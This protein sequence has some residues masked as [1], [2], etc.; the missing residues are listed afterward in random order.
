MRIPGIEDIKDA[1]ITLS[2]I[3]NITPLL[4]SYK[5]SER[6]SAN[7]HIKLENFQKTGSFKIR[8]I[9]NKIKKIPEGRL[10]KG[11]I[12]F[13]DPNFGYALSYVGKLFNIP[14]TIIMQKDTEINFD[15]KKFGSDV[16]CEDVDIEE[17]VKKAKEIAKAKDLTYIDPTEDPDIISGYGTIALE[18]LRD[19][20]S[21][22]IAILPVEHGSLIS[23][24]SIFSK[25][26]LPQIKIIGAYKEGSL[27]LNKTTSSIIERYVDEMLPINESVIK[28]AMK[29]H[30]E[31]VKIVPEER[32]TYPLALLL[33]GK[34]ET[35]N[36]SIALLVSGGNIDTER[37]KALI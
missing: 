6:F 18:I 22:E 25:E 3:L 7:I 29:L 1:N 11:V 24:F 2:P 36:K 17:G 27:N 14:T 23:G 9:Y 5:L 34:V 10:K 33:D 20:K 19:E 37:L 8:G 28:E 32:A 15:F 13:S 12:T 31:E 4:Y 26:I 30:L 16:I 21:I 35:K